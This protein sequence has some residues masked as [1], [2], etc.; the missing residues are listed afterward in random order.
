M[1]RFVISSLFLISLFYIGCAKDNFC[2]TTN[3]G[4]QY[5]DTT[6]ESV[7]YV[8]DSIVLRANL[9][10]INYPKIFD[11]TF[12]GDSAGYYATVYHVYDTINRPWKDSLILD[13]QKKYLDTLYLKANAFI[14]YNRPYYYYCLGQVFK[15][16]FAAAQGSIWFVM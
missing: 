9:F 15:V 5:N 12:E 8:S 10:K 4:R 13:Y 16:D 7:I 3:N 2:S 1:Q 14:F 6:K 11:I